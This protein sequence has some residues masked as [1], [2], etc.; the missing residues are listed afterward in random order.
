LRG[1]FAT[2]QAR[3]CKVGPVAGLQSEFVDVTSH[4]LNI[5][6]TKSNMFIHTGNG[7]D[8]VVVLGGKNVVDGGGGSNFLTGGTG[9]DTFFV[10]ARGASQDIWSTVKGFHPGDDATTTPQCGASCQ[11]APRS[12]GSMATEPW[13]P[14]A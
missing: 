7:A 1:A 2:R 12:V 4:N 14:K 3:G 6:A 5:T 10:D 13:A 11:A 9:T 8:A